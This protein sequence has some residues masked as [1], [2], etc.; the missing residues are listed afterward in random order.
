MVSSKH[1]DKVI[2]AREKRAISPEDYMLRA[3]DLISAAIIPVTRDIY[4]AYHLM[5]AKDNTPIA[6]PDKPALKLSEACFAFDW[7]V[8]KGFDLQ[9]NRLHHRGEAYAEAILKHDK[10][11]SPRIFME[12]L[13][14]DPTPEQPHTL[15]PSAADAKQVVRQLKQALQDFTPAQGRSGHN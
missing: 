1:A 13:L 6:I 10:K 14:F 5:L 8:N 15:C 7:L 3:P 12:Q 11:S 2:A 9:L 4:Q